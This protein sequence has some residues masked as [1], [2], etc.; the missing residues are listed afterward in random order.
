[1]TFSLEQG[2]APLICQVVS[3][4]WTLFA[5]LTQHADRELHS[6]VVVLHDVHVICH[7]YHNLYRPSINTIFGFRRSARSLHVALHSVRRPRLAAIPPNILNT[8]KTRNGAPVTV[9][10]ALQNPSPRAHHVA[11]A[12]NGVSNSR[13]RCA[14][15]SRNYR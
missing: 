8:V 10:Y 11:Y 3:R 5:F 14:F 6:R 4:R 13:S 7:D 15:T 9:R 12:R 1:M 2:V